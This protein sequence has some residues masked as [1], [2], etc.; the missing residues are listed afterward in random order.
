[1]HRAKTNNMIDILANV[2]VP[3]RGHGDSHEVCYN[4]NL[5]KLNMTLFLS[6]IYLC[7]IC[8]ARRTRLT[9]LRSF[10]NR[11]FASEVG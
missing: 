8:L 10:F 5:L 3:K 6:A 1:M 11:E 7:F 4:F 2:V 9:E